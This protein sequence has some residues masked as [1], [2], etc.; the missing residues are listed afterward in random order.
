MSTFFESLK[1]SIDIPVVYNVNNFKEDPP[2]IVYRGDG[3]NTVKADDTIY[4]KKN[5]YIIE[6]YFNRKNEKLE[7]NL[8]KGLLENGFI[9][10]KSEDIDLE[11]GKIFL[12]YYYVGD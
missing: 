10:E 8:E 6:Y 9:Y 3:Q 12:I 5:K 11:D 2:F 4:F 7:D 1:K